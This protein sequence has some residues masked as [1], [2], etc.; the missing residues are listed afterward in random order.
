M[1]FSPDTFT[2]KGTQKRLLAHWAEDIAETIKNSLTY[3]KKQLKR[4]Q[5][6]MTNNANCHCKDNSYKVSQKVFVDR[7]NIKIKRLCLKLNDKNIGLYKILQKVETAYRL[8]LLAFIKIH[9]VFHVMHLRAA[10]TDSLSE[11]INAPPGPMIVNDQD[12]WVVNKIIDSCCT[13][14]NRRL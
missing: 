5:A 6:T 11:Q 1:S 13:N 10:V 3:M 8:K 7:R 4:A 2:Y 12:E 9:S 14:I